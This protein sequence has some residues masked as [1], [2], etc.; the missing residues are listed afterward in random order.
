[1]CFSS[2]RRHTSSKRD[3]SS[4]VC[5]SDLPDDVSSELFDDCCPR[6]SPHQKCA[7]LGER[8]GR[9]TFSSFE[10][11]RQPACPVGSVRQK[12]HRRLC[13]TPSSRKGRASFVSP[14]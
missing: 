10:P 2:R 7:P 5:S 14:E 12:A 13:R 1:F 9:G 3:W 8:R 4:D 6:A 11:L